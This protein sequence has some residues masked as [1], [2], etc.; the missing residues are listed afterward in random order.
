MHDVKPYILFNP[1][2]MLNTQYLTVH[3]SYFLGGVDLYD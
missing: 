2:L 1:G 3:M